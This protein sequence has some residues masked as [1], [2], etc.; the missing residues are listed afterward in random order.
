MQ[1]AQSWEQLHAVLARNGLHLHPRANGLV[2]SAGDGTTIKAS[3]VSRDFSKPQLEQRFGPFQPTSV[4]AV[5]P[6]PHR[7]YE[8]KPL[9]LGA[10]ATGLYAQYQVAQAQA[11]AIRSRE[12]EQARARKERRMPRSTAWPRQRDQIGDDHLPRRRGRRPG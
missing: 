7:R 10:N 12:W 4:Q 3:S 8:R 9:G 2:I 5:A 11:T 6:K 1:Q